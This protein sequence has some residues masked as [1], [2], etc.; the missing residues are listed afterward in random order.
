LPN[1]VVELKLPDAIIKGHKILNEK[2]IAHVCSNKSCKSPTDSAEKL[3]K[4][5]EYE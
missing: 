5:L 2:A 3:L 1:V 4:L